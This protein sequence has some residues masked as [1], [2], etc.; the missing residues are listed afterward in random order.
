MFIYINDHLQM[1][2]VKLVLMD[3]WP[4]LKVKQIKYELFLF[5]HLWTIDTVFATIQA[6]EIL[7]MMKNTKLKQ[8]N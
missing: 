7:K 8:T 4:K 1:T 5:D 3:W 6:M 2:C